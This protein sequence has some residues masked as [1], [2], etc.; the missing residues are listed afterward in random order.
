MVFLVTSGTLP[1]SMFVFALFSIPGPVITYIIHHK[2]S[3]NIV[4][5][6]ESLVKYDCQDYSKSVTL[7]LGSEAAALRRCTSGIARKIS[8]HELHAQQ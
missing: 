1:S 3:K 8:L 5:S 2:F 4:F 7:S 6:I